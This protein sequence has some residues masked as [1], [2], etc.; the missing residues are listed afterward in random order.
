MLYFVGH[1]GFKWTFSFAQVFQSFSYCRIHLIVNSGF[2]FSVMM[3]S[4]DR[5]PPFGPN[6]LMSMNMSIKPTYVEI[7]MQP[8]GLY[9]YNFNHFKKKSI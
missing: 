7:S 8:T 2:V 9:I 5:S 4:N 6:N 3:H 1:T